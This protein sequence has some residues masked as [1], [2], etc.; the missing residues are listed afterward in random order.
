MEFNM[1]FNL[2]I[3]FIGVALDWMQNIYGKTCKCFFT[4]KNIWW[5]I[6]Q[7]I[8]EKIILNYKVISST[9]SRLDQNPELYSHAWIPNILMY[10][11]L[12]V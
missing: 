12:Q 2:Q 10:F 1:I 4:D 11:V 9:C 5:Y 7:V 6:K 3:L 8:C